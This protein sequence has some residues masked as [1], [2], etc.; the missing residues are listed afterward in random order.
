M[1]QSPM[2]VLEPRTPNGME[3]YMDDLGSPFDRPHS[4]GP[5]LK[6][7]DMADLFSPTEDCP[8]TIW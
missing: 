1:D 7:A 8:C 6:T 5:L 2:R 3:I 4:K